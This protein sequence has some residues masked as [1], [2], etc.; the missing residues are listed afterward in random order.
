MTASASN[1]PPTIESLAENQ[2][3]II[4]TVSGLADVVTE[5]V[6]GVAVLADGQRQLN[7]RLDDNNKR[8][9]DITKR[10]DDNNKRLDDNNKRLDDN[11]KRL[12]DNN[13]RLDDNNKRL[14]DNNKRLDG[15]NEKLDGLMDDISLVKGGHARNETIRNASLI[16]HRLGYQFISEL[17][18]EALIGFAELAKANDVADNE[19]E[20]F[21]KAD[22]VM[23][24]QDAN[25]Q[26]GYIAVEVS[27]TISDNDVRRA[28]RNAEYLHKYTGIR[29]HAAVA[30]VD[31]LSDAK[32]QVDSGKVHWYEIPK[33]EIQPT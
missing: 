24:A 26:P 7:A 1:N 9:D 5:L 28:V 10:L 4:E 22:L 21:A 3:R 32:Q 19:A 30:G 20:S 12:D 8:L 15:T 25:N 6:D 13:K 17:R 11:N 27:F 18:Q 16:A 23:I 14:D 29:A 33:R 31:I 2:Q